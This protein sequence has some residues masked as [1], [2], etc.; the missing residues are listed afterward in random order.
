MLTNMGAALRQWRRRFSRSEWAVRRLQLARDAAPSHAPGLLLIQIDGLSRTQL[1]AAVE[2]GRLPFLRRLQRRHGCRL[3]TFYPGLPSTTPAVQGELYYGVRAAVPAFS[4]LDPRADEIRSMIDPDWAKRIE[5][6][7]AKQGEG[8]LKGGSSWSNIYTGGA[9]PTESHY[10]A[11]SIGLGDLW[12][13]GKVTNLLLFGLLHTVSFLRLLALVPI[14]FVVS[15]YEALRG[16]VQGFRWYREIPFIAARIFICLGL[17]E[18]ITFGATI[19]LARGLPIIH[20]N[21]LGYDEQ[22]H[23]RGPGSAFAFWT[24]RGIDAAIQRLHRAARRSNGRD[25]EVWIFSDHGQ[26]AA[27]PFDQI[28]PGGLEGLVRRVWPGL[29]EEDRVRV[30]QRPVAPN[31]A[32]W[33]GGRGRRRRPEAERERLQTFAEEDFAV[34]CLGPVGH[35]YSKR[36]LDP[37]ALDQ[38]V[39]DLLAGGVPGVL[40]VRDDQVEWHTPDQVFQLPQDLSGFAGPES[41]RPALAADLAALATHEFAGDLIALGWRADG[42]SFSFAPENG[43]H[44]GPSPEETQGFLLLPPASDHL[45]DHEF[46]R[47]AELRQAAMRHLGRVTTRQR[48]A[49]PLRPSLR[50]RVVTY[51]VHYCKGLDGRFAPERIARVLHTLDPDII[52]LQE[53]ESGR[54][55]S[56]GEDQL[57]YLANYLGLS[58]CF[59]ASIEQGEERYGHA[60]LARGPLRATRCLHLP[61]G[62]RPRI[63]PRDAMAAEVELHGRNIM[64]FGTHFGLARAERAA[65]IDRM[66]EPDMLGGDFTSQPAMFLGDLNLTPGGPLYQRLQHG[67]RNE[68]GDARFRDVVPLSPNAR[69]CPTFPAFLP[70]RRLDHIFVT[71]H[72]KVLDVFAHSNLLTGRASDHLPLVADLELHA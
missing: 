4:F 37:A 42:T 27:Q 34:A 11:A 5:A 13:T 72:F 49:R 10:C 56:R 30:T 40:R 12:R 51:N 46:V 59:C 29:A 67:W 65:Q 38:L 3:H 70:L 64:L 33:L 26:I 44:A 7:L 16:T 14:E 17:R 21:F 36:E 31:R 35:L 57:A 61:T 45:I 68:A 20:V 9:R 28:A 63:E 43:S 58:S 24:L 60:F 22:A 53:L 50:L 71:P 62:G 54:E 47:P 25:Y 52:A 1:E 48:R 6:D 66:V 2:S 18:L 23:R 41:Q 39:S 8:L 69:P 55:R 15:I 19:D 32:T